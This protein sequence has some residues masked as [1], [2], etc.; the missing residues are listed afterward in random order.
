MYL[1]RGK[2]F[3]VLITAATTLLGAW[4]TYH[5]VVDSPS[6]G[7]GGAEVRLYFAN[8]DATQVVAESRVLNQAVTGENIVLELIKGPESLHLYPTLPLGT[9]L[10]SFRVQGRVAYVDF[11]R[12]VR[13]NFVGGTAG[14]LMLVYS[15]IASLTELP[16][17]AAVH[18]LVEGHSQESIWGHMDTSIP[19]APDMKFIA[20]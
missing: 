20:R 4:L 12:E 2:L 1:L 11:S 7:T 3:F 6:P 16:D 14:E 19:L 9:R 8:S 17:I 15:V 13:E 5:A 10:F 18:F